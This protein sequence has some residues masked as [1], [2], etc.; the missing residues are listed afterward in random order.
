MSS[1]YGGCQ[2]SS[3]H[4]Y[5]CCIHR[6]TFVRSLLAFERWPGICRSN[7][8]YTRWACYDMHAPQ[9]K[10]LKAQ[11]GWGASK[12]YNTSIKSVNCQNVESFHSDFFLSGARF[13]LLFFF[14]YESVHLSVSQCKAQKAISQAVTHLSCCMSSKQ[15]HFVVLSVFCSVPWNR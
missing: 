15:W 2:S 13:F 5:T 10:L 14:F 12:T 3:A 1:V 9:T 7:S 6:A 4:S 8:V 11:N